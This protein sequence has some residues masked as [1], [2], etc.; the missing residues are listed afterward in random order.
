MELELNGHIAVVTGGASGIGLACARGFAR[1]GCRVAL[2]DV[3]PDVHDIAAA[4]AKEFGHPSAGL[5]GDVSSQVE[6]QASLLET[7]SSLGPVSHLVHAAAVGSGR[8]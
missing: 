2:W 3:S 4:L 6:A 5:K 1:E 7:E 8:F